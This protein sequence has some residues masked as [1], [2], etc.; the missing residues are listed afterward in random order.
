MSNFSAE[1]QKGPAVIT[2]V[3]K[4]GGKDFHGSG[5]MYARNYAMNSNDAQFNANGQPRPENKYYYP[6]FTLG[7]P[8]LIPGT[9]LNKNRNKLFFFTGFEY[10]YQTLD[11]GPPCLRL[12]KLAATSLRRNSP[13]WE[14]S[15]LP[16]ALPDR[17][18]IRR[19]IRAA[20][21]RRA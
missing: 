16:A 13:S 4:S 1:N 10:F 11:T 5:F 21:F 17:L 14:T 9:H 19:S 18:K 6:G 15:P 12:V 7:G 2:S 3:A 20:S 8:V